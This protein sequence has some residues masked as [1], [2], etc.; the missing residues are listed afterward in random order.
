VKFQNNSSYYELEE[1]KKEDEYI[2]DSELDLQF[3]P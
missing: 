1:E 3:N 2:G